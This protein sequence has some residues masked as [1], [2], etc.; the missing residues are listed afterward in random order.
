MAMPEASMNQKNQSMARENYV[1]LARK[2]VAM[3]PESVTH[4]VKGP[5]NDQLGSGIPGAD[6]RHV[7][8][9]LRI[10]LGHSYHA[11]KLANIACGRRGCRSF[12]VLVP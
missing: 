12:P 7:G 4:A 10:Y 3:K 2:I 6:P 1:W 5:S 11:R 9:A 8:A